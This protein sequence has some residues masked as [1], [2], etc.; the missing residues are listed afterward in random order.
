MCDV[1]HPAPVSDGYGQIMEYV[2]PQPV[3]CEDPACKNV[4]EVGTCRGL[5][6]SGE[7]LL[8]GHYLSRTLPSYLQETESTSW[9]HAK[10]NCQ[11]FS[12]FI[13][14]L[15]CISPS[16][17]LRNL[18]SPKTTHVFFWFAKE[19]TRV[20]ATCV[21]E[22]TGRPAR[23][24]SCTLQLGAASWRSSSTESRSTTMTRWDTGGKVVRVEGMMILYGQYK[25]IYSS[26]YM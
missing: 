11:T 19:T 22:V 16:F 10:T 1:Q 7:A 4:L 15:Q 25:C 9:N 6:W 14:C 5:H 21:P 8:E 2:L 3:D 17:F 24:L 18:F 23:P 12:T 26:I 13:P 20:S